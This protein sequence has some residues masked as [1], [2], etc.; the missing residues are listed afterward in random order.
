MSSPALSQ[1]LHRM[2]ALGAQKHDDRRVLRKVESI[3]SVRC[4]IQYTMTSLHHIIIII[5][6][7]DNFSDT[8][9]Y[10]LAQCACATS[11]WPSV[12]PLTIAGNVIPS[13]QK[14]DG[15]TNFVGT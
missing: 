4:Y 10:T 1:F 2:F 6:T 8:I 14:A 11:I 13:A 15:L 12:V 3:D 9:S 5:I 7:I